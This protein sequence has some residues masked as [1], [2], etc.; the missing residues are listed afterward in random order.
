MRN[1]SPY[2]EAYPGWSH[3]DTEYPLLVTV[4]YTVPIRA[5]SAY[6][7]VGFLWVNTQ[8]WELFSVTSTTLSSLSKLLL[9][10]KSLVPRKGCLTNPVSTFLSQ[11]PPC[12]EKDQV[13]PYILSFYFILSTKSEDSVEV[14]IHK[15]FSPGNSFLTWV[16]SLWVNRTSVICKDHTSDAIACL[17][18]YPCHLQ[19]LY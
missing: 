1:S 9:G 17:P 8:T 5:L 16:S 19:G 3:L 18:S 10:S 4:S 14:C 13:N 12:C 6:W 2:L 7:T 11:S 15:P